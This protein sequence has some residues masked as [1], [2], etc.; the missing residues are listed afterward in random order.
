MAV[1]FPVEFRG[2]QT[3]ATT[4]PKPSSARL[5]DESLDVPRV[6]MST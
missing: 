4:Q 6:T 1:S 5:S 2:F 3:P